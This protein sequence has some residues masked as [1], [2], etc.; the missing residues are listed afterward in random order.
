LCFTSTRHRAPLFI[1]RLDNLPATDDQP[2]PKSLLRLV[3]PV[4]KLKK[5]KPPKTGAEVKS[6]ELSFSR[7]TGETLG[8]YLDRVDIEGREHLVEAA[9]KSKGTSERRKK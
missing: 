5:K 2:V 4:Q 3:N 6:D 1:T 8:D 9:K 7:K